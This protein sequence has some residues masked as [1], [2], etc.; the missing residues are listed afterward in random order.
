MNNIWLAFITGLT[1]GGVSCL[2]VQGG[3]LASAV[4]P[5]KEKQESSLR[6]HWQLVGVFLIAK[7]ISY[8]LLGLLLGQLGSL[9]II[10]PKT[11][12]ML[13]IF[14]GL[15]M[16]AT[17]GRLADIHPIF[18][19]FA[20]TPP[21]F[22]YKLL[23]KTSKSESIFA[24][25]LLGFFTI[26][27]PCG[28]T[29]AMMVLAV[30]SGNALL[31][32]A[33]MGAFVL[34]TSPVFFALGATVVT[35]LSNKSFAYFAAV[36]VLIFGVVSINGG[37]V[38]RGSVFTIQNFYK[39]ATM[40]DE[41]RI[42]NAELNINN[43]VVLNSKGQQE[44]TINVTTRGYESDIVTLK[45]GIPVKL[46]LVT[47][48]TQ[49]CVRAFTIPE[50]NISKVLPPDGETEIEF[51]PEKPGRLAYSCSMGMYSGEFTVK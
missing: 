38:A 23:K 22:S 2:A 47:N 13:Q 50:Y 43:K 37:M 10:S 8:T 6:G 21:K 25:A 33:I 44:A 12:G 7:L 4:S 27:M 46:K 45:V 20:I 1:T 35:L 3:L 5:N 48:N 40:N 9:L 16:V 36:I 15:F 11:F 34:G 14:A 19:Y 32:G 28:L 31:G 24:P 51:T 30:A 17:A 39:A 49:G 29:Q 26:L 42:K 18:R 41:L